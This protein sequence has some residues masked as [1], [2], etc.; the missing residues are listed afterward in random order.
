MVNL[1]M[2]RGAKI[3]GQ[4]LVLISI[5]LLAIGFLAG[6]LGFLM[7]GNIAKNC[8][9]VFVSKEA[10]IKAEEERVKGALIKGNGNSDESMFFGKSA[11]ALELMQQIA[12]SYEDRRT[13]VLFLGSDSGVVRNGVPISSIVHAEMVRVL[14]TTEQ[15]KED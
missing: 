8:Q 9:V 13:K 12:K 11:R 15:K 4:N 2:F 6:W 5:L 14:K 3:E 10:I 7:F 1:V